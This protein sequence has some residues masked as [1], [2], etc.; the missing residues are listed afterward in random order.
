MFRFFIA[1]AI[2]ATL[3]TTAVSD[4]LAQFVDDE[5]GFCEQC[6]DGNCH[7]N[8]RY[9]LWT[10]LEFMIGWRSHSDTP[11]LVTTSPNNGVLPQAGILLGNS[12][13]G[14]EGRPGGRLTVGGWL[15][16]DYCWAVE[17][18]LLTLGEQ[19]VRYSDNSNNNSTLARPFVNLTPQGGGIV[20]NDAFVISGL[21]VATGSVNVNNDADLWVSDVTFRRLLFESP[22]T[23]VD[24]LLG[25]TTSRIDE[26]LTIQSSSLLA[27]GNTL[28]VFDS[29]D[30]ENQYQ[31]GHLGFDVDSYDGNWSLRLRGQVS[32]GSMRQLV[33]IRGSQTATAVGLNPVVTNGG[34]YAQSTNIGDFERQRFV[35]SPEFDLTLGYQ[36]SDRVEL[37]AGYMFL[38][39]SRVVQ[40]GN[41]IDT[42]LNP[43]QP[44]PL[45]EP[46][47]PSF[48]FQEEG[49]YV[50]G[51]TF[52]LSAE[53]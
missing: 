34:L 16:A 33:R 14:G 37:T 52:G 2:A 47:R 53:F 22:G 43:N 26:T 21:G 36:I 18:R 32:L 29:F 10:D 50:H 42:S 39:W 45:N 48:S 5:S 20:G 40:P 23:E 13:L 12:P 46:Q 24:L 1:L 3:C 27:I 17:G 30:V 44:P 4:E 49:Y 8:C 25:Y 19:S 11:T 15:D 9:G 31:A 51:L 28:D 6:M 38:Y 7:G 41:Q 35:V